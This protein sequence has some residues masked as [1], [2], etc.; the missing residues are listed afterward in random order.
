MRENKLLNELIDF[1]KIFVV[2]W[3]VVYLFANLVARP[4]RVTGSSMYPTLHD[5][6]FGF[7]NVVSIK[8]DENAIRRFDIVV[9]HPGDG[10]YL[11]KRVVGL[12][13][14]HILYSNNNLYVNGELIE[15]PFLDTD[16][17]NNYYPSQQM[18]FTNNLEIQLK[19]DEYFCLGDN[20]PESSDSRVYGPFKKSMI[21][22]K[23]VY[24]L[25]PFDRFLKVK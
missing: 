15:E 17:A 19:A 16:Y 20:R 11:V 13:G 8:L 6:D 25:F 14:E 4:V 10:P 3:L 22:S 1:L 5:G 2:T 18:D 21:S 7:S 24:L 23:A 9:V 12:P